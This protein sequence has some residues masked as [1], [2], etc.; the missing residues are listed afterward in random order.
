MLQHRNKRQHN[1][2]SLATWP[3]TVGLND[4]WQTWQQELSRSQG[5]TDDV[6]TVWSESRH[7]CIGRQRRATSC[8]GCTVMWYSASQPLT[9]TDHW[10]ATY[11]VHVKISTPDKKWTP[12]TSVI[13]IAS[14]NVSQFRPLNENFAQHSWE[15]AEYT[16]LKISCLFVNYSLLAAM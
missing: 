9:V 1:N 3:T 8:R 14:I 4:S 15:N 6:V 7:G 12:R 10:P 11:T 13:L 2:T 5:H 16:H